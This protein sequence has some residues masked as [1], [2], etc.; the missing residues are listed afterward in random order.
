MKGIIYDDYINLSEAYRE[1]PK[2]NDLH[3]SNQKDYESILALL[4]EEE[5][6]IPLFVETE[7]DIYLLPEFEKNNTSKENI[8]L[9]YL[10]K[11]ITSTN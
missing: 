7:Q 11:I 1:N 2:I 3:I 6:S 9:Y 8:K 5:K 10:G 4:S